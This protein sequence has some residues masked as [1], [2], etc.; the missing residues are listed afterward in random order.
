[1]TKQIL[2]GSANYKAFRCVIFVH[3][4]TVTEIQNILLGILSS[5]ALNLCSAVRQESHFRHIKLINFYDECAD[6]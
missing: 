2:S 5:N 1:V 6:L 3:H 4:V